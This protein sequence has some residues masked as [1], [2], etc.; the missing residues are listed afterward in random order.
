MLFTTREKRPRSISSL[1][2]HIRSRYMEESGFLPSEEIWF[3]AQI[4]INETYASSEKV[5]NLYIDLLLVKESQLYKIKAYILDYFNFSFIQKDL[6][7][8]CN[9]FSLPTG[10]PRLIYDALLLLAILSRAESFTD[11]YYS[12]LILIP[13]RREYAKGDWIVVFEYNCKIY[14]ASV[15][16][17]QPTSHNAFIHTSDILAVFLETVAF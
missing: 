8:R 7:T 2:R 4:R 5:R 9:L 17:L 14:I 3:T 11:R 12:H 16:L 1:I 15:N 13:R 6:C 10:L